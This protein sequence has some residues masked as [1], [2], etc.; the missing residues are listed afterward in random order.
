MVEVR[1]LGL[2]CLVALP[3]LVGAASG[4]A[5]GGDEAFVL[6]DP[7]IVESSGL[8]VAD[9]LVV[10]TNDSGDRSSCP[11]DRSSSRPYG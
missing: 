3:F 4:A 10:T 7:D 8:L 9:G 2:A 1:R 6:G 11:G 5:A